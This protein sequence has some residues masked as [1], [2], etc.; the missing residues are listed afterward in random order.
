MKIVPNFVAIPYIV[1][2]VPRLLIFYG[3]ISPMKLLINVRY[4]IS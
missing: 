2:L 3:P 1:P 4:I